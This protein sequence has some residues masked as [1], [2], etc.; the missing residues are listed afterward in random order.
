MYPIM[1]EMLVGIDGRIL[2]YLNI[3][4]WG[5]YSFLF[6]ASFLD[7]NSDSC[8]ECVLYMVIPFLKLN[9]LLVQKT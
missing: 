1:L 9:I 3:Y 8:D 4:M 2:S 7:I 5:F 6:Y